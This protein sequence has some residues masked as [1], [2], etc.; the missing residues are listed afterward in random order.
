MP[1]TLANVVPP[2]LPMRQMMGVLGTTGI[3]AY[4]GMLD[5]GAG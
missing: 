1:T 5:I 3:T 4:F 2:G